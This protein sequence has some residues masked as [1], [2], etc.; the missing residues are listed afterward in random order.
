MFASVSSENLYSDID[1]VGDNSDAFPDDSSE[2]LDSDG[3]GV[4]D[5]TDAYPQDAKKTVMEEEE[6]EGLPG[7]T[8]Y[9]SLSSIL[10]AAFA[11]GRRD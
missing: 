2:T 5:N 6:S 11:I 4:G 3:D 7:F 10:V 9:L 8:F 1:G